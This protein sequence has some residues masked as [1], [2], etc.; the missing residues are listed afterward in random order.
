[1]AAQSQIGSQ[2]RMNEP[3]KAPGIEKVLSAGQARFPKLMV[4]SERPDTTVLASND[5]V[6]M[7]LSGWPSPSPSSP[8]VIEGPSRYSSSPVSYTHL[9]LPTI[10]SV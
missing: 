3:P 1:M 8:L 2:D 9:T 5:A 6:G 7:A 4:S 10:C